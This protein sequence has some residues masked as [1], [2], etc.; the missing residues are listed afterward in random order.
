MP[1]W[2]DLIA[3]QD[4]QKIYAA[5]LTLA[6]TGSTTTLRVCDHPI[7]P[8][9]AA[10]YYAP[11][12]RGMPSFS[13]RMQEVFYGRSQRSHGYLEIINRDG[14]LD[15]YLTSWVWDGQEITLRLGFP[16]LAMTGYEAVITGRMGKPTWDDGIVAVPVTCFQIDLL[17]AT[18]TSAGSTDTAPNWV[19]ALLTAAGI[20]SIDSTLWAAWSSANNFNAYLESSS[21]AVSTLL[22]RLLA[23]LACW[24]GFNRAGEFIIGTFAAPTAGTPDL[25]LGVDGF[26]LE[27]L[28]YEVEQLKQYWKVTIEYISAT[29]PVTYSSVT[30][31]DAAIK[32]LNPNAEAGERKTLLTNPADAE[33]VR[34]RWWGLHSVARTLSRVEAKVQPLALKLHDEVAIS[35]DRFSLSGNHRVTGFNED[36]VNSRIAMELFK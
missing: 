9:K 13:H 36:H 11:R 18:Y 22:D 14:G 2:P 28:S 5:D 15:S 4:S 3:S 33:T 24:Y 21:E 1:S 20:T 19:S 29:G 34:D 27:I 6:Q 26:D 31:Q 17:R 12:L 25:S 35:R 7:P 16:E 10:Y 32:T 8:D 23:P 30:R